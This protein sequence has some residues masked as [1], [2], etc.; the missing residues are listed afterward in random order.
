M[1]AFVHPSKGV[2]LSPYAYVDASEDQVLSPAELV[3]SWS[4]GVPRRWGLEDG[5]GEPL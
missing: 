3:D 4:G 2:R 5:T 1:A